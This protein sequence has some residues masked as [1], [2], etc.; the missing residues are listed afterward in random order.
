MP[1]HVEPAELVYD[2]RNQV[3]MR[4]CEL[5]K[6]HFSAVLEYHHICPQSWFKAAGKPVS[7]PMIFLCANCHNDTHAA[8]DALITGKGIDH[9]PRFVVRLAKQALTLAH[10]HG[11]TPAR[12]L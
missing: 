2:D 6:R 10:L 12:T 9:M 4:S 7:T 3:V 8:I 11:L 1:V 5:Y